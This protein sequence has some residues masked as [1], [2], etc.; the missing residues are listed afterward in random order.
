[1]RKKVILFLM[2]ALL[3]STSF[4][5]ADELTVHDGTTT[6]GYVPVYGFYADAYLKCEMVYPASELTDMANGTINGLTFYASDASV[7]WGAANFQV[8]MTEVESTAISAFAGPGTV[9]YEGALSISGN[10]MTVTFATPY[11]YNGGNLLVGF[12]NTVT[13]SYVSCSWLGETVDGASVQGYSYSNLASVSPTQRNFLPKTTFNYTAAALPPTP[14]TPTGDLTITPNPFELGERPTNGWMEP[15]VVRINN[16]GEPVTLTASLSNTAGVNAFSLSEGIENVT[17]ATGDELAFTIDINTNAAAGDYTEEFT[18]FSV[19]ADR[20]IVAIPVTSTFYTAGEADIVETAKTLSLS[21]SGG[22]ANFSHTPADLHANY[23]LAGMTE[24]TTDAV[25]RMN[26]VKDAKVTVNNAVAFYNYVAN[27]QPSAAIEPVFEADANEDVT[28]LAGTYYMIVTDVTGDVEGTV[29]QIPAPTELVALA[30]ADGATEVE[31][32]VEL[33]WEGGENA[34]QYRV[35][36]GTSPVNMPAVLDWTMVDANYG[37]YTVTG[38]QANT[39]YFWQIEARNSNGTV[40]TTR[41]GF[42]TTLTAPNTVTASETEIFTD[43]TTL[44]KWKH[45]TGLMGD[46]PE[47]Q[48]GSGTSTSAYL[49][50]YNL[51]NYSLTEQIYTGEEI[52]EAGYINSISFHP[53]GTITRNLKV[54]MANTDKTSFTSGSDWVTMEADNLVYEGNVAMVANTWVTINLNEPFEFDGSNLLLVVTDHTGTWTSSIQYSTFDATAQAINVYQDSA[55]YNALAPAGS[56]TVRNFKNQIIINKDGA[57]DLAEGDRGFI[58][59]NVYYGDV[60]ANTS[61]LTEKQFLL[62]NLPY[63]MTGHDINVTAVYDEG[64]SGHS[65]PIVTVKVSGYGTIHGTVTSLATTQAASVPVPNA[66]VKFY[67]KDE[68]NNDVEFTATTNASGNYTVS[69]KAGTY[70]R[71]VATLAGMEPANMAD[72]VTVAYLAN[73]EVNFIIHEEYKPVLSVYAE[74]IDPTMSK[75]Q[76]SLNTAIAGGGMGGNG[77]EFSVNFDDS[78]IPAGWTMIDANNDGYNWVLGS[79]IG[80][81]YLASGASLEGSGH[82][83]STDLICSGSYSNATSQAITPDNY[84]VTPQVMLVNG[85]TFSFWA[86]A[87]DASYAAEHY[88]VFISDNATGPWTMVQEW[89][90]TAKEEGG[91][92]AIGR[93][94]QTRAQGNWYQKSVDLSA[95]A[96]QKYIAIRHFNCNDMFIL[97]VDDIELSV[98]SKNRSVQDYTIVRKA[99]LKEAGVTAADSITLAEHYIDTLYADFD[100]NNV[101]PGLYQYGVSAVYPSALTKRGNRDEIA[102]GDGTGNTYMVPFNS[103]YGYSFTEQIYLASEIGMAGNINSISF[104][105]ANAYTSA[106]TNH[107]TVWMKNVSRET[108]ASN[109]DYEPVT[110]ADVVFEGDWEI[111]VCAAGDWITLTLDTPFAYD[112]TSNLMFAMHESTSGYSTRYFYYTTVTSSGIS[113]YSDSYNP[114][115]YNLG[116]YS[117]SKVVRNNRNNIILDITPGGASGND[118]PVTPITW[119]NILPKDMETTVTLNALVVAGSAEGATYSMVNDFEGITYE[120]ELDETGTVT[121][122]D[123]RKGNYVVTVDLEGFT[124]D[125]VEEEISIWDETEINANLTEICKPVDA[126]AVSVTGFATWTAVVPQEERYA[127]KYFLQLDGIYYGETPDNF[128]QLEGLVEGETY[129]FGVAV[130]Y[131]TGMS[132]YVTT[133]F[134]Y[135]GCEGVE[136]QVEGLAVDSTNSVDWNVALTWNGG[137]TPTPPTPGEG[138]WY[139]YGDDVQTTG[140]GAGGAFY[141][142][143][144]FPA[145]TYEGNTVT[146]VANYGAH[147]DMYGT[148]GAFTGTVTI[149]NDGTSA[150]S[151]AVGTMNITMPDTDQLVEFE[152]P[153]PITIDPSKNLWVVFYNSNSTDYVGSCC[154]DSGD[155]NGRWVSLDGSSWM[156]LATAGVSGYNW[157]IKVYVASGKGEVHEISAPTQ[158]CNNA[159]MLASNGVKSNR[160]MWDLVYEFDGTSGYQ[161]GVASDG[162]YIYTSSWSASSTS[163]FY[164][165]DMEGNFI[166]EFN[167]SGCGQLRGMTYDGEYFYGVANSSTIYCVDLANHT[168]VSTTSSAYG[169]MRAITYDPERDGFWVVGNWSGNLTLV[170]RTGAIVTTGATPTSASDVAY[171]KD[172]DGVEHVFCFNNGDNGVYDYNIGTNTIAST[173]VFNFNTNPVVTG[174]SGGCFVGVYDG[175]TCFFGDIQQSPQHI[176]IYELDQDAPIPP[177]P[178]EGVLGVALFRDGEFLDFVDAS[179][180]SYTDV[181][182]YEEGGEY[183]YTVRVAYAGDPDVT[184]WAMS[185]GEDETVTVEPWAIGEGSLNTR[186]YPNPTNGNVTIEAE[187]MSHITVVNALGQ[188]VYDADID[189]DMTQLNLGQ[190]NAGLYMIRINTVAG[191][192]VERVTVVK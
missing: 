37:S 47:T 120:G 21:Y 164:K 173:A 51:Y 9:V 179:V 104:H 12:Y 132:N 79:Q 188:V 87:Q 76:W 127:E 3:G 96:G 122:N 111:P 49:P 42:T 68:F 77:D 86:C 7:S 182:Q 56:G 98:A 165:Y 141:W 161:Y 158:E 144:M 75:V 69:V 60:K 91:A 20:D 102:I 135:E 64:E 6:N 119:S 116:S 14:P 4:L 44:I 58:G 101:E 23:L 142:A 33:T 117:G 97:D 93:D 8:F 95:Y 30:P 181:I 78:T 57:K 73:E 125:I 148:N 65:T 185:C 112:G 16:G 177:Q 171:Y 46:L 27:F 22:V 162:E 192:K 100:W 19:A 40:Q 70:N 66:T 169:A 143:V 175:K 106:Q 41:R 5:R 80:G 25:Y 174:S 160:D 10:Q 159:G 138:H 71:G 121:I 39:Q 147:D 38:L 81:V 89:T 178:V 128:E 28:V 63:N 136:Q 126:V 183:T 105:I 62:E 59:Y 13:G 145:G 74:E 88:G 155:A 107:Y 85:S 137:S 133:T 67:G 154:N 29:E 2:L 35:L 18:L 153:T 52:G 172:P 140:V 17:L 131:S 50:T 166:E 72:P 123:F 115:P 55:P 61:L 90:M 84:L 149:Y 191:V 156:D 53:V 94:G 31:S 32:P 189:A 110:T 190:Y 108:F 130:V 170:S 129:T 152:F 103:L 34:A 15:Y 176:A 146:K 36:F 118:D 139:F 99:I 150:P 163:M 45:S 26:I 43:G 187:G 124:S 114:D 113:Y 109:T 24:M 186:I 134:T 1:M 167:I 83:S 184:L 54:Y 151:T 92:M 82:N 11:E 180:T 48:I 157:M 168:L